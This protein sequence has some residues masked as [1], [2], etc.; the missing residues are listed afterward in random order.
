MT[1]DE[2]LFLS[3]QSLLCLPCLVFPYPASSSAR[4]DTAGRVNPNLYSQT[5]LC[6]VRRPEFLCNL[7][8]VRP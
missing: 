4:I 3:L 5:S 1:A 2:A 7:S 6:W 8:G